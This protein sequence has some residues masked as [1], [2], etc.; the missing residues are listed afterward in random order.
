MSEPVDATT[1]HH[2]RRLWPSLLA[3]LALLSIPGIAL[4]VAIRGPAN[5][6]ELAPLQRTLI[7]EVMVF[8][9]ST[10]R[11]TGPHD[12]RLADGKILDLLPPGS[13]DPEPVT[14]EGAGLTLLPGLIDAH[15]HL[16]SGT[17]LPGPLAL[18]ET[19]H[20]LGALALAGVTTVLDTGG[21]LSE[22]AGLNEQTQSQAVAGPEILFAGPPM[23]A[24]NG[25]PIAIFKAVLPGFLGNFVDTHM[26]RPIATP[27][28]AEAA[29]EAT[30]AGGASVIKVMLDDIP[31]DGPELDDAR[32]QAIV[33][34][35]SSRNVPVIAHVG[36][37]EDARRAAEAGVSGLVHLPYRDRVTPETAQLLGRKGVPV[38]TTL[39]VWT[40]LTEL[41]AQTAPLTALEDRLAPQKNKDALLAGLPDLQATDL[42]EPLHAWFDVVK[43]GQPLL[44]ENVRTM[45]AAGVPLL[46]GS[47]SANVGNYPGA[48]LH[49]ELDLLHA[50]GVPA[51]DVLRAATAT[52]ASFLGIEDRVG[53]VRPDY[54]A[55]LLLVRGNPVD[56]LQALHD[57]VSVWIDGREVVAR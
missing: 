50:A 19:N 44:A 33:A 42:P 24:P 40:R 30:V 17:A 2:P 41:L 48:A 46:A 55:D 27:A 11:V 4:L 13:A 8:E 25:H 1:P 7:R 3:F 39:V 21:P 49:R 36:T 16:A 45:R 20:H 47:D 29:V 15:V 43:S 23:T 53:A 52:N 56:D 14:V 5:P 10:G 51:R 31:I 57:I 38:A 32:L 28:D 12:V 26:A 22:L 37:D 9:S 35:A 34:A 54:E 18:P 6:A